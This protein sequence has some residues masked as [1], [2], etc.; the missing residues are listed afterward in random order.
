MKSWE[1]RLTSN[2]FSC[3]PVFKVSGIQS[4]G[5]RGDLDGL[6]ASFLCP[7][8]HFH[9]KWEFIVVSCHRTVV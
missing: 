4:M 5:W 8:S 9:V 2:R 3:N 1:R 6:G 7:R